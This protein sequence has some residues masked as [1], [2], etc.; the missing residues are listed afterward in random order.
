MVKFQY[1]I[2]DQTYFRQLPT[3]LSEITIGEL[4]DMAALMPEQPTRLDYISILSDTPAEHIE[5]MPR[6]L[7]DIL[8]DAI[9][10]M[11]SDT[12][13]VENMFG[14]EYEEM[15]K[16]RLDQFEHWRLRPTLSNTVALLHKGDYSYS[17]RM[18]K[19]DYYKSLPADIGVYCRNFYNKSFEEHQKKFSYLYQEYEPTADEAIAGYD[20]LAKWGVYSTYEQLAGGDIFKM[21]EVVKLP[22]DDVYYF[23]MYQKTKLN[24]QKNL[25]DAIQ[26]NHITN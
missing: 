26:R 4:E 24:Y 15:G 18:A 7:L 23:L 5:A 9:E 14:L 25:T 16:L 22:V 20:E 11:F 13:F 21:N 8:N 17:E 10:F 1:S 3:K 6:D 2:S 12:V 19:I